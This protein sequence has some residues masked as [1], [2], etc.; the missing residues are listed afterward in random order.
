MK[1][2]IISEQEMRALLT[3]QPGI[4]R[5]VIDSDTRNEVDDQFAIAYALRSPERLKVEAVY[6]APFT[7]MADIGLV[8]EATEPGKGMELSYQEILHLYELL[9]EP[10]DG[11]VFRGSTGYLTSSMAPIESAAACD[12]A[13]RAMQNEEPLYV[14][15]IGAITNIASAILLNPEIIK[16]IVVVWLGGQPHHHPYTIEFNLMQDIL[17][18]RVIFDC[19]VPLVHI[20]CMGVASNLTTTPIELEHCIGASKIGSYLTEIVRE[21]CKESDNPLPTINFFRD[22]YLKD[23]EDYPD[24][25]RKISGIHG[26]SASRIIWDVSAIAYAVNPNWCPS[27]LVPSP[28]L[29]DNMS[30]RHDNTRH[31]VRQCNFVYR[32]AIFGDMFTKLGR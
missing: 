3:P 9:G 8:P 13:E 16:R 21:S 22:M 15:A 26:T 19:G 2:P 27:R 11:R 10:S 30:W 12:L 14:L 18:S 17:A 28:I 5:V 4:L 7:S 25:V 24:S 31:L 20:P 1:F 32:N 29:E 6:A 23:M